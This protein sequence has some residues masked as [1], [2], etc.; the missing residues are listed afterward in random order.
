MLPRHGSPLSL[1]TPNKAKT[2]LSQHLALVPHYFSHTF[3]SLLIVGCAS[4]CVMTVLSHAGLEAP[5]GQRPCFLL[6]HAGP[7][8]RGR[9]CPGGLPQCSVVPQ[10]LA[11]SGSFLSACLL[12]GRLPA[13]HGSKPPQG[14]SSQAANR[15]ARDLELLL[16]P[17]G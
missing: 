3:L 2:F 14:L 10:G 17:R 1:A 5:R 11:H 8:R 9:L 15:T 4:S 12:M 7:W 13:G 16:D 6:L